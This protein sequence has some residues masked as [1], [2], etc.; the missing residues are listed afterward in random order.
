[1]CRFIVIICIVVFSNKVTSA[2]TFTLDSTVLH[3]RVIS[4]DLFNPWDLV[5]GPDDKIWF[6][7]KYG[8]IMRVDPITLVQDTVHLIDETFVSTLENSGLHAL[9]IH[10]NFQTHPYIYTHYTY[11]SL[12]ARLT[13]W[14]YDPGTNSLTDSLQIIP[15]MKGARSHNGSRI[16]WDS[17][18]TFLMTTG[19]AYLFSIA[20]DFNELNGKILR[21][22]WDGSTPSDNPYGDT[23]IYA[24]GIRN[25][26]GLT[27]LPN[28]EVFT[29][30]HGTTEDDEVNRIFAGRNY[31]WPNVLGACDQPSEMAFCA[32]SNVVEP[33]YTWT[34]TWAVCGLDWYDHP[35]IPELRSNLLLAS[36][37]AKRLL[38]LKLDTVAY[39]IDTGLEVVADT[40]G[41]IREVLVAPN[42]NIYIAT[43]NH[44]NF[45]P[46]LN[47]N[48][49][50][51]IELYNPNFSNIVDIKDASIQLFPNPV[52][53]Y[54]TID[55]KGIL[56]NQKAL[57][58][59]MD[60]N[61]K[62]I[63]E[64]SIENSRKT[65]STSNYV[66]GVYII[67]MSNGIDFFYG[68]F[69]KN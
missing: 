43:S 3:S 37:K 50:K 66:P 29:S 28:G 41:R 27:I 40:F 51:I 62:L 14:T 35:Q 33:I 45:G 46:P 26:Q 2:Q 61:G 8:Y 13:R 23:P 47:P 63:D 42:G 5:W 7:T 19:D 31:G 20:Q 65:I 15:H 11:D 54:F 52:K 10:P 12:A 34:P 68:R 21:F 69:V 57:L 36:L 32:D 44:E 39:T 30:E 22:K 24:S 56:R 4:Q 49:D 17:D 25:S 58:T 9:G 18:S 48:D 67:R 38:R 53:D 16:E 64:I 59:I 1:M 6:T 60:L 55:I